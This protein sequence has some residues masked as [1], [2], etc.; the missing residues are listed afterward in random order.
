MEKLKAHIPMKDINC[1]E[2]VLIKQ[3][4]EQAIEIDNPNLTI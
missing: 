4:I 2:Q 1:F 3:T